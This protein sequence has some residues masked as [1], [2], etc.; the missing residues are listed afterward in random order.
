MTN[1][2]QTKELEYFP[3][4]SRTIPGLEFFSS[5]AEGQTPLGKF[6]VQSKAPLQPLGTSLIEFRGDFSWTLSCRE[7]VASRCSTDF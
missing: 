5:A 2:F 6:W 1:I 3:Q 4:F 7:M